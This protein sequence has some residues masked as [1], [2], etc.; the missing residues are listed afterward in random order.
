M[1]STL[2]FRNEVLQI[3][4]G[5]FLLALKIFDLNILD[6]KIYRAREYH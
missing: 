5:A 3:L 4:A 6:L 2:L 1:N